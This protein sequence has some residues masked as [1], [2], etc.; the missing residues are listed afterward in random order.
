MRGLGPNR[1]SSCNAAEG[2]VLCNKRWPGDD[3]PRG[4]R[5]PGRMAR[6]VRWLAD[7]LGRLGEPAGRRPPRRPRRRRSGPEVVEGTSARL[8]QLVPLAP[9]HQP[10]NLRPRP[11]CAR[12]AGPGCRR[13]PASTRVSPGP[14]LGR[15]RLRPAA[16]PTLRRACAAT[17]FTACRTRTSPGRCDG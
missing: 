7:R 3:G 8:E 1:T 5:R 10:H 11:V 9:L 13:W 14:S 2:A 16:R 15:R 4:A 6:I 17:A 12:A